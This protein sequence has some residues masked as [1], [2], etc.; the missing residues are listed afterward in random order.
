MQAWERLRERFQGAC[1]ALRLRSSFKRRSPVFTLVPQAAPIEL[2]DYD[3]ALVEYYPECELQTKRWFV[4]TVGHDWV[5]CD[6]GADIGCYSILCSRL[7]PSGRVLAFS[8]R[9]TIRKLERNVALN[10]CRN[11]SAFSDLSTIDSMVST[12]RLSRLDCI[13]IQVDSANL[14]MLHG[15]ASTL[16]R[17]DPWL[18]VSLGRDAAQPSSLGTELSEWLA[19]QGYNSAFVLDHGNYVL[20]RTGQR[21]G[22]GASPVALEFDARPLFLQP[23][24]GKAAERPS[25]FKKTPLALNGATLDRSGGV[26]SI[27]VPGPQGSYAAEWQARVQ[28]ERPYVLSFDVEVAQGEVGFCLL[29][30]DGLLLSEVCVKP[31]E[32]RQRVEVVKFEGPAPRSLILRNTDPLGARAHVRLY[33]SRCF[34]GVPGPQPPLPPVLNPSVTTLSSRDMQAALGK[35]MTLKE[36]TASIDIVPVES[37][38][39]ALGFDRPFQ[40]TRL[41]R[42][43]LADFN[44]ER[45]E[46]AIFEYLYRHFR[47]RRHLEIGTWE[48]H[49][50]TTV[51][52]SC[53]AEIWTINLPHGERDQ[54]GKPLYWTGVNGEGGALQSDSAERIGWRYRAAGYGDRVHQVYG[55]S[56]ELDFSQWSAGFFDT[57]FIDGG[58]TKPVVTN[59]TE[60]TFP[61]L[62]SGGLMIWHDFCPEQRAL[63]LNESPR[64]VVAAVAENLGRWRPWFVRMFWIRPSWIMVG[65]KK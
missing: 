41:Y 25:P 13:R 7:A 51:A 20:R 23:S 22:D 37:L 45:D 34:N 55:D 16:R 58:H 28:D 5:V 40:P 18:I 12:V 10:R 43:D 26:T 62:R 33:G 21:S 6:V 57:I 61:L 60:K 65:V 47:P 24:L 59:D 36:P 52:R 53:E 48:G 27:D 54:S 4:E 9:R 64:G 38:G 15:A 8:P 39:K 63:A 31:G 1:A 17:F 29:M 50:A 46:T 44:T 56:L 42:H 32:G 11:V 30:K 2:I 49:G 3:D 14:D 35:P 19:G